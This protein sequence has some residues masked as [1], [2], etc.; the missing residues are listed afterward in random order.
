MR[1]MTAS[2]IWQSHGKSMNME[3]FA[4]SIEPCLGSARTPWPGAREKV[5]SQ[6]E[7]G[8]RVQPDGIP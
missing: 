8:V 5:I 1:I 3:R 2:K 6:P 4:V 7:S